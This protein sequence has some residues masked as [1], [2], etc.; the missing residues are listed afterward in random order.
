MNKFVF[1]FHKKLNKIFKV[2]FELDLLIKTIKYYS[3]LNENNKYIY[4]QVEML[5]GYENYNYKIYIKEPIN[6]NNIYILTED[7]KVEEFNEQLKKFNI[8]LN[9]IFIKEMSK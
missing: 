5:V 6:Y 4:Y 1:L 3:K 8:C 9:K 2:S 7:N